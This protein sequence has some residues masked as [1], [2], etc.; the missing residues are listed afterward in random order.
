MAENI[1]P[2]LKWAGG[3]R[4]LLPSLLPLFPKKVTS[5]CEPFLG[6]ASVLFSFAPKTA[7]ANDINSDL[8]NFYEIVRDDVLNLLE[9]LKSFPNT[10]EFYYSIRNIDRDPTAFSKLTKLQK[11]ARTFYL[12]RYGYNGLYRVNSKGH[13]N[14]P[15]GHKEKLYKIVDDKFISVSNYLK[16]NDIKIT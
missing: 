11:A 10:E 5:Y 3:K 14:S 15:Y 1:I 13:F 16:N 4:Q 6:G 8:V 9:L 12:N 2:L 7:I